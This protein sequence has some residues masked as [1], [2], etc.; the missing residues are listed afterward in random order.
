MTPG[1]LV[2]RVGAGQVTVTNGFNPRPPVKGATPDSYQREIIR[3]TFPFWSAAG[4]ASAEERIA[5]LVDRGAEQS[6]VAN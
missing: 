1:G 5:G 6:I 3:A 4:P 2:L